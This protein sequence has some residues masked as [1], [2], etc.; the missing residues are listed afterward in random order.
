MKLT[1]TP[2]CPE[3]LRR[4]LDEE[5][6]EL[7]STPEGTI[8][9]T[10]RGNQ[11]SIS[12]RLT[13]LGVGNCL[14]GA[15]ILALASIVGEAVWASFASGR[16]AHILNDARQGIEPCHMTIDGWQGDDCPSKEPVR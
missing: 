7:V 11:V 15:L 2:P 12:V 9:T 4:F 1:S 5:T 6:V 16:V 3:S 8:S 10:V 14:L 13:R